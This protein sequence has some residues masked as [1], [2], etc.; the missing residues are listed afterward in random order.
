MRF[1][2]ALGISQLPKRR[3]LLQADQIVAGREAREKRKSCRQNG[4]PMLEAH[5]SVERAPMGHFAD[6]AHAQRSA[7]HTDPEQI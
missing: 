4:Y 3:E 7:D 6:Q 2:K 1:S 5:T